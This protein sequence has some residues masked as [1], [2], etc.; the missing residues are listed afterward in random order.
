MTAEAFFPEW[1]AQKVSLRATKKA[2][3]MTK[4]MA[5]ARSLKGTRRW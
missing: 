5:W 3:G 2:T 1:N 4:A